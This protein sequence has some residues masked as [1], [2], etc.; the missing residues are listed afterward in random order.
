MGAYEFVVKKAMPLA[1]VIKGWPVSRYIADLEESQWWSPQ[2]LKEMQ[3]EK[4]RKMVK[5]AYENVQHYR[6]VFDECG[7]TPDDIKSMDDLPKLPILT[8]DTVRAKFPDGITSRIHDRRSL[9]V[10]KSSGSTGEPLR[11]FLTGPEKAFK[12]ACLYRMWRWAGYDFGR[13]YVNFTVLAQLA[14]RGVPGL[15]W[16]ERKITRAL[17]LQ[18]KEMNAKNVGDF[19][20]RIADFHPVVIKGHPSTCYY[21]ARYMAEHDL[22][23][24]GVHGTICNGETL[25]PYVREL[26]SD[27]FGCG[28]WDTY[29]SEGIETAAQCSPTSYHHVTAEA[30]ITEVCDERGEPV[31]YGTEGRLVVTALDK[32]AMPFIRYDTQDMASMTDQTCSCGR[33]LPLL[34]SVKGRMVD[35]GLSP[36]GKLLSVYAFTPLFAITPGIDAWQVVQESAG[37]LVVKIQPAT[38]FDKSV[39]QSIEKEIKDYVGDDVEVTIQ[40]VDEIPLTSGGKRRFFISK[41]PY[42]SGQ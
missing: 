40:L 35:M 12:W 9:I 11:Y 5:H 4:L 10:G 20:R 16:L 32:W 6:E 1:E 15:E 29:G 41:C 3:N 24:S 8:K 36:S 19:V 42:G 28:V 13:R 37:E 27:R 39:V 21:M 14:F 33:G 2:Q 17:I 25:V 26:I 30:V 31:P 38:S 7:L 22:R 23:F 34:S 18:A